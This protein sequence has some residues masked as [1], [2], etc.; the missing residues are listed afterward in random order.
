M[1][2]KILL[3]DDE[4]TSLAI[5]RK[6]LVDAGYDVEPVRNGEEALVKAGEKKYDIVL[7]DFSMPGI[8]GL[9]LTSEILKIQS[10]TIIIL[11]TAY[12][13]IKSSVDAIKN[14]AFDYL[15]KPV[16]KEELLL[17]LE[18]ACDKIKL[19]NEN[20]LLKKRLE[21]SEIKSEINS[22]Y[23]T[24]SEKVKEILKEAKI[25]ASS[26]SA[27][28]ITGS[29]GT[30]KE[31]LAKYIYNNS[32]RKEQPFIVINCAAIPEQ[33]LESELFG[34]IKGSF[35]GAIKDKKGYFEIADNGTI[36]L[37]E[38]GEITPQ[39]QV[40]LLRVLQEKEFSK[41]GDTKIQQTNVRIIS[42]TNRNIAKLI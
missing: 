29:N 12:A 40:K 18:R 41:L 16:N 13:S 7:T 25:A 35:T 37:D 15:T 3:V 33:L 34:H 10:D 27:I 31:V 38:I 22:E 20:Q 42:A 30:G 4:I 21:H 19:L 28:M 2:H 32:K 6:I 17:S 1:S 14:G 9:D 39:I 24:N 26:D 36:F 5:I 23:L 11:I 8:S